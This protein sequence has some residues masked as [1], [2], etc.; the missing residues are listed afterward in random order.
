VPV[1]PTDL[2]RPFGPY[3]LL[4][5]IA[6]GGMGAVYLALRP[7]DEAEARQRQLPSAREE[8]CV[9]K[10]VRADLK[11]DR[12]AL[13]RFLDEARVVQKLTH[14][15]IASTLD[16]GVIDKT[17]Y[18][19]LEFISGRNLR[20]ITLRAQKLGEALPEP[21]IF[22]VLADMLAAL[23]H[24][25]R[26]RDP[27][28]GRPL[29]IVHRDVS[30]HNVMLGFDGTTK[31][32][33]FGL[34]AHELKR[35]LTRPGVMVG[36]LRYNAPEQV[37][38][39]ALDGRSD[40]YSAGVVLYEFVANE[41]FYEGLTEEMV[42]KV[43]MKG[44]HRPRSWRD[45]DG[46]LRGLLEVALQNDPTRRYRT[47]GDFREALIDVARHRGVDL[48]GARRDTSRFLQ[49]LFAAEQAEEREMILQA[50][51]IAEARTR[52]FRS[53]SDLQSAIGNLGSQ[54][55]PAVDLKTEILGNDPEQLRDL[56]DMMSRL[57]DPNAITHPPSDAIDEDDEDGVDPSRRHR[58]TDDDDDSENSLITAASIASENRL[59]GGRRAPAPMDGSGEDDSFAADL[60]PEE[61]F[62]S[63]DGVPRTTVARRGRSS[64]DDLAPAPRGPRARTD[65]GR[66]WD[67]EAEADDDDG[68]EPATRDDRKR[69]RGPRA[70]PPVAAP[71]V[72]RA[73]R[74]AP[75][76]PTPPPPKP[77][78][79]RSAASLVFGLIGVLAIGAAAMLAVPRL[80]PGA[81]DP[82]VVIGSDE[83]GRAGFSDAGSAASVDGAAPGTVGT[84]APAPGD[85]DAGRPLP[86]GDAGAEDRRVAVVDGGAE[87]APASDAG[88]AVL[89][90]D[91]GAREPSDAPPSSPVEPANS[92]RTGFARPIEPTAETPIERP[93]ERGVETVVEAPVERS[94][95]VRRP[96]DP[97]RERPRKT[98]KT[99]PATAPRGFKDQIDYLRQ[100]CQPRVACA[101]SIV[102]SASQLS[103]LTPEELKQLREEAPRCVE[104]CRR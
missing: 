4:R 52:L 53:P 25:H 46:D 69:R 67:D 30:P 93:I 71:V 78:P 49:T 9:V 75:V 17:Y 102:E 84:G 79:E 28:T 22:H 83:P 74:A 55:S 45:I 3:T 56:R 70:A 88:T 103:S 95:D 21:L 29:N 48:K 61:S 38:D 51:G 85:N 59:R 23:D 1:E 43:A 33:D 100:Y 37:R 42:W 72:A 87:P 10:T 44:D 7:V 41:R 39:R 63:A 13:G 34:A 77:P 80:L 57:A 91:A 54:R 104:R 58:R 81:D 19:C 82:V 18:L 62:R 94:P 97:P 5:L 11:G 20:D 66:G 15:R 40:V 24:A 50:T 36:K 92:T 16:A 26:A 73:P 8:V 65:D 90:P 12:E 98:A 96:K 68:Q 35:E 2:P 64:R 101:R 76:R 6:Q 86:S 47:A 14:P 31:L 99:P 32:I 89:I 60:P 27:E